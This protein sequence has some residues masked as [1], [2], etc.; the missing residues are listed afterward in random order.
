MGSHRCAVG[1]GLA[2]FAIGGSLPV[3]A[4]LPL[5]SIR[6]S[7]QTVT[8]VY[9]GWYQ[10][11]DGTFSLSFGYF[12][13]NADE[14]LQ[15]PIGS[16]NFIEPGNRDQGQPSDFHPR[17]HW[18]VFAVKVP[19]DFG[20]KEVVWTL[21]FRGRTFAI[22]GSLQPHWQIDALEG[23]AGSGN[24]PPLLKFAESGPEAGG[25]LGVTG[26]PLTAKVGAALSI[27]VWARDD[28][29]ASGN[30][31]SS[32]RKA[33]PVALAWFKHRGPGVVVFAPP[34]AKIDASG[35]Q[36]TTMASFSEAGE[37]VVRVRANDASGVSNAG[38]AQ[39]CWTNGFV[40]VTVTR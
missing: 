12:N 21:K 24:T 25:P 6:S 27:V 18:G 20:L 40:K 33:E 32:G 8:P 26:G 2:L 9:E 1:I 31:A 29:K 17:R 37:Y 19:A 11:P 5:A 14:V 15:I 39:C 38:H 22:P 34:S 36:A 28:G 35:G 23:E 3:A 10:N 7:G 4:Q 30:V 13:R 16:D